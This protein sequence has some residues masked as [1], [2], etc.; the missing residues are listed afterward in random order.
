MSLNT[1]FQGL[2]ISEVVP[3][4]IA[5]MQEGL[6]KSSLLV[7]RRKIRFQP[8]TGTTAAPGSIVQFVLADSS[9]LLDVNSATISFT[10]TTTGTNTA[11]APAALDDGV[12]IFRRLQVSLN[13][14]LVSDV[15]HVH[16]LTNMEVYAAAD[17]SWYQSAAGSFA[18]FWKFNPDMATGVFP[19]TTAAPMAGAYN[20]CFGDIKGDATTAGAI[21][22]AAGVRHLAGENRLVPLSL[23]D[24]FFRTKQ[25]IPLNLLGELVLSFTLASNEE[26]CFNSSITN[27]AYSL[28]DIFIE[29]DLVQPHYMLQEIMTKQANSEGENGIVIPYESA[30]VSQGQSIASGSS[31]V[32]VSRATNNL[33]RMLYAHQLTTGLSSQVFPSVSCFGFNAVTSWQV[34]CGSIYAPSQP[35]TT[36]ARLYGLLASTYGAAVNDKPGVMNRLTY[37]AT[38]ALDGTGPAA[39]LAFSDNFITGYCFDS[40]KNTGG[41]NVLDADGLSV[42]GQAGSQLVVQV[43]Q[44]GS[45]TP[46]VALMAT[47]YLS[48]MNGTLKIVGV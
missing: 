29:C 16:R 21:W 39:K 25:Y 37:T 34:R 45:V 44:T 11:A 2:P 3:D 8:Q 35:A 18:G 10:V 17:K 27:N 33:R 6:S 43:S 40:Y 28:S 46:V 31:S 36:A 1:G 12:S 22:Q 23:M 38:T 24:G 47:K 15:D 20:P 48:L 7:S 41:T 14:N 42:L 30:I 13:G 32:I 26:A 19:T 9:S 4:A 5:G